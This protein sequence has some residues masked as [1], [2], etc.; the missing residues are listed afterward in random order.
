MKQRLLGFFMLGILLIGSAYAQE[1]RI[2]GK[3][4]SADDASPLPG[5]TVS[6]VGSSATVQTNLDGQ[7]SI[8]IPVGATELQFRSLGF[9]TVV[10]EVGSRSIIDVTLKPGAT[11]IDEVVVTG[12]YGTRQ[13]SRSVSYSAQVLDAEDVNVIRQ[14][15]INSALAGKVAG[16]QL[17]GQSAA[18]LG[19]ETQVRLRGAS[20]FGA[21]EGA[22]YVVDGTIL[23]NS[24]DLVLD[25]I[26][27][28]SI[29]QGPAA[30]AQFG[31]QGANGAI[32]ITLKK[33]RKSPGVGITVNL[34]A[35]FQSPYIMPNYQNSYAGGG[36]S[37]LIKYTWLEGHPEEWKALDGKYYHDYNDDAS[38]GPRMVGQEYIPWYAWYGGHSRSYQTA[39]LVPQPDNARDFFETGAVLNNS[40]T[41]SSSADKLNLKFTYNNTY[42]NGLLPTSN[43]NKNQI[44]LMTDYHVNK[45]LTLSANVNY[46]RRQLI[47]E[48]DDEYS[49]Q[50]TGA[51]SQ[52]FHRNLDMDILKEL[53]GLTT[54]DGIYASW[55]H[56]NPSSYSPTNERGFYAANY[57]YNMYTY[58]DLLDRINQR[59]RLFGDISLTYHIM[60][61][62]SLT[63]TYRKQQNTTFYEDKYST[64]LNES[65]LQTQGNNPLNFGYYGTGTTY[66][67]RENLDFLA[68]Y[69]KEI[70]DFSISATLGAD[71]FRYLSKTNEAN[72]N[73]GLNA[74]DLFTI[75]NSVNEPSIFNTRLE[76]RYNAIFGSGV[77]GYKNLVFFNFTLRNDWFSTLPEDNNAVL[78]K[79]FG[80]SF[81]FSDVLP[82]NNWFSYGKLRAAW[83]EIPKALGA[84]STRF[85][86]Y[87]YPGAA[88]GVNQF[89]WGNNFLMS[90]PDQL[91][92]PEISGSVVSQMDLGVD[93]GFFRDNTGRDRIGL[94]FTYWDGSDIDF[95][96]PL[97]LN[98]ASGYTSILTNIGKIS[99]RGIDVQLTVTPVNLPKFEWTLGATY[100]NLIE[101][102]V[103]EVSEKYEIKQI[104]SIAGS[105][106]WGT[107][108]PYMIHQEKMRW[109]QIYGNGILR[110]DDGVP[111][112]TGDGSYQNDPNVF[113]GSVLPRVTGGVQNSF[114]FLEDF[115]LTVN[116]DYQFGGKFVSLSN[117]WGSYS[118]LTARTAVLNDLGN[119]IRDAVADGGGVHV[120][121]V[122]ADN[123]PVDYYVDAQDYFH[124]AYN[125]LTFDDYVYDLT[126]V[127]LREISLGYQIPVQKLNLGN[128]VRS[129]QVSLVATNPW[130]LYAKTKDFDP[131]EVSAIDGERAQLPGTRGIGFNLR[132]SF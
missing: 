34:G 9:E 32:V 53:R 91:V 122:N 123:E 107:T 86:A 69:Q 6:A 10:E 18:A 50:S 24:D 51:F 4:I 66:S 11:A 30:S 78:S 116:I 43:L 61:G 56:T 119:P 117:M 19:R 58:Y 27:S 131:G 120:F 98:G 45:Y 110:N 101:N 59:D 109:G 47:G 13:T 31:S 64:R 108:L 63:G 124:G 22:I 99:K 92:D 28:V 70:D 20:G 1:R 52:W 130:L 114:T 3:V 90:T 88:Y 80:A 79:S 36:S 85:G 128:Y 44:N 57:W 84:T 46:V 96:Q 74:P 132:F 67:N 126:F 40:I 5:V 55:N 112:L 15:S 102:D 81:V 104:T 72:T 17:R 35:Q 23:P 48:I 8:V 49:N 105:R 111:I 39:T 118:G 121:G 26:E 115:N 25:D 100:S 42:V 29:L 65:G 97:S 75:S 73:Q 113:F 68:R 21:G 2:S 127:K 37:N 95:P 38:W 87:L 12:A 77:L 103:L 54:P 106:V 125:N 129:A 82:K 14:P 16:L 93:L 83:G 71:F 33:G 76:E 62:L 89:K 7:Y 60:E 94:S 41:F